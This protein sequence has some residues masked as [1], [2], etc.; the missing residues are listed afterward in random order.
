MAL[1]PNQQDTDHYQHLDIHPAV[2]LMAGLSYVLHE[3]E[4]YVGVDARQM[5]Y[6]VSRRMG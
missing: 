1:A 5:E 4:S 3:P 6:A 2:T